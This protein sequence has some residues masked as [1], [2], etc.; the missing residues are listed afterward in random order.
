MSV[1]ER[2][3]NRPPGPW[4][5][6]PPMPYPP[7]MP[8]RVPYFI[9]QHLASF[10]KIIG[11]PME[12]VDKK[13]SKV[14]FNNRPWAYKFTFIFVLIL[15]ILTTTWNIYA[16]AFWNT[17]YYVKLFMLTL[18]LMINM[19]GFVSILL[20]WIPKKVGWYFSLT[21]CIMIF[22]IFAFLT[23]AS[24]FEYSLRPVTYLILAIFII[25]ILVIITLNISSNRFYFHTGEVPSKSP[26]PMPMP[27]PMYPQDNS[28]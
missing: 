17:W 13:M 27:M 14:P 19:Y 6:Q 12:I 7:P 11:A 24:S 4:H 23:L 21:T 18:V 1:N 15:T 10:D 28:R 20:L 22:P 26:E 16:L 9:P 25:A 8:I 2:A 5:Q 3:Q